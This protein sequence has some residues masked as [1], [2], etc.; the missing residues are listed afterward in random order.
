MLVSDFSNLVVNGKCITVIIIKIIQ[1]IIL[2]FESF[3]KKRSSQNI[4]VLQILAIYFFPP[5]KQTFSKL[6]IYMD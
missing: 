3:K 1:V 6:Q 5:M 4:N 2:I